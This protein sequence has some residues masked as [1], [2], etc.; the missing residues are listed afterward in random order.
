MPAD[1]ETKVLQLDLPKN[2]AVWEYSERLSMLEIESME[3]AQKD[4][5][6]SALIL[7]PE[8]STGKV[9]IFKRAFQKLGFRVV[10]RENPLLPAEVQKLQ[11]RALMC[12]G[13]CLRP[14][15]WQRFPVY[16]R[17]NRVPHHKMISS[18]QRKDAF[19]EILDKGAKGNEL[20]SRYFLRWWTW[21]TEKRELV[22][23]F[24]HKHPDTWF[25]AKPTGGSLGN[26]IEV[27]NNTGLSAYPM[28]FPKTRQKQRM[29]QEY[30][31][32][33]HLINGHKWDLRAYVL[34][35][36][37]VPLRVYV[38]KKGLVRFAAHKYN[39]KSSGLGD[40]T[41]F[42]TNTH[43]G[44]RFQS[45]ENITWT[46]EQLAEHLSSEGHS[47][48]RT[49]EDISEAT[50]LV[51]QSIELFWQALF[52][53]EGK[54]CNKCW[55]IY[56][57]DLIMDKNHRLHVLELNSNPDMELSKHR[58]ED[59]YS[60]TKFS[61]ASN[62]INLLYKRNQTVVPKI[63]ELLADFEDKEALKHLSKNEWLYLIEYMSE[64]YHRGDYI[65]AYPSAK[66]TGVQEA[67]LNL[68]RE[69]NPPSRIRLHKV[70][71]HLEKKIS[72]H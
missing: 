45:L 55:H 64:S 29:I 46:Y 47:F 57:L 5:K 27:L 6:K 7:D 60:L 51:F 20:L 10:V 37:C 24:A 22:L 16:R 49:M 39:T 15:V 59:L 28:E 65:S 42:L 21:T 4:L 35:T 38:F 30:I 41:Q 71:A 68:H 54:H 9:A 67:M 17:V 70:L 36:S 40:R 50:F 2:A 62:A 14:L 11:H 43:V 48:E 13:N 58:E 1:V 31:R 33:P 69:V 8:Y 12:F 18:L 3:W 66:Y 19:A 61:F 56:G 72:S 44:K 34:V 25:I 32:E 23:E 26:N 53:R 52:R 63:H